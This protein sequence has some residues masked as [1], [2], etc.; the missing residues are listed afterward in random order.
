MNQE[1]Q[2]GGSWSNEDLG[3]DPRWGNSRPHLC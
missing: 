2:Q 3:K 1:A